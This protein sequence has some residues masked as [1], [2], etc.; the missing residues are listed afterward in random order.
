MWLL[1]L[2]LAWGSPD[3]KDLVRRVAE[4]ERK[5]RMARDQY[6]Y[7][8]TFEFTE[9]G[10]GSYSAVSDVTFT[11]DGRRLEKP[12][13][14]PVDT[15]KRIRLTEED[16]RDLIEVQPFLLDPE[17]LW[18]YEVSYVAEQTLAGIPVHLLRVRPRQIFATQRLFDGMIWVGQEGLQVLQAEG[19]AVPNIVRKG[20]E[21]LFPHF[22]TVRERIVESPGGAVYWFP[23]LTYADDVLPFRTGPVR[24]RFTIKYEEY[25]RFGTDIKIVPL[26]TA[27]SGY[28]RRLVPSSRSSPCRNS[29]LM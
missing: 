20:Q 17:D 13:K 21:N 12:L 1:A 27:P 7:R 24:V 3:W 29:D 2:L 19:K 4:N 25:K 16:F 14:K 11:A 9:E 5:F 22:T 26:T 23:V 15:L 6:T 18:N 10:G 28:A 8:Q